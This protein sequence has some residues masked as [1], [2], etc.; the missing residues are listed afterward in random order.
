MKDY[1]WEKKAK[2]LINLLNIV[3]FFF[4]SSFLQ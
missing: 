1:T 3:A 4:L 2:I